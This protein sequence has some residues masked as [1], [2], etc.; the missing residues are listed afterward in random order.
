VPFYIRCDGQYVGVTFRQQSGARL[1]VLLG[2]FFR[3]AADTE[4]LLKFIE[5]YIFA[6]TVRFYGCL[7]RLLSLRVLSDDILTL[8]LTSIPQSTCD[9]QHLLDR[10]YGLATAR[11]LRCHPARVNW[12]FTLLPLFT[13]L[14][15][16]GVT[17]ENV[18]FPSP[19]AREATIAYRRMRADLFRN[20]IGLSPLKPLTASFIGHTPRDMEPAHIGLIDRGSDPRY[21]ALERYSEMLL[22]GHR[23]A[24]DFKSLRRLRFFS[25]KS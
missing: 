14:Q 21:S 17:P 10:S 22:S 4:L 3:N 1:G 13:Y 12:S 18:T 11:S 6:R 15:K 24:E 7:Q 23:L 5:P 20:V 25:G 9:W 2:H 8:G 19:N 16:V